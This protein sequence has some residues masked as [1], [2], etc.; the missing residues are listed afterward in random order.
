[1]S[2]DESQFTERE[3]SYSI[4]FSL[5][6]LATFRTKRTPV[7]TVQFTPRNLLLTAGPFRPY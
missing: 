1:M 3:T 4:L 2:M 7:H 5:D 6:L